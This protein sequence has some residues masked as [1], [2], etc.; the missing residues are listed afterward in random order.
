MSGNRRAPAREPRAHWILLLLS[1]LLLLAALAFNGYAHGIAGG[2][3]LPRPIDGAAAAPEQ[4][5]TGGPVIRANGGQV[6]SRRMPAK[7]IALT[8]DDGP[9]PEWTPK[10][11]D[12]LAKYQAH[13]TFF[14]I[15]S[16]V[17]EYPDLVRRM[18]AEGHEV[19]SHTFTHV[20]IARVA[21]WRRDL[22]LGMTRNAI[23]GAT[24]REVTLFR[25]PF[26]STADALHAYEV[27]A[28]PSDALTVL[29]D[30]D[31][32]DWQ[33]PGVDAIVRAAQPKGTAGA[34]VL[35]H[36]SGGDR[37]QTVQALAKLIPA[38][39]AKGYK[40][41]TVSEALGLPAAAPAPRAVQVRGDVLRTVQ[42]AA[43]FATDAM[44]VL[45]A[46]AL[47]LAVVRLLVQILA[48][49]RHVKVARR[50]WRE[51]PFEVLDPVSII[52]PAYNEA[53]NIA[54]TV[55][56]LVASDY[57]YLEVIVVDDGSTDHTADIVEGLRLRGVRVLRQA[58]AGKPAALTTG[59]RAAR[60]DLLI[61]VDGDTVFQRDTVYNLVQDFVDA[62]VGAIAGNTKVANRKGLLG[63]WQHLE[64]V[65]GFNLDRRLFDLAG[66]MPTI[67]GA[68]G[69]FRREVLQ[70]VAT[71]AGIVSPDTLA[72]DTDLTMAV[73]RAGWKV[74]YAE[75]A[76]AWTEAPSS[77]RQLWRQRYRWCYGT[78]QAMWKHRHAVVEGGGGGR[79]G[80][81]GLPYLLVFQVALPLA[82]P[83]V[84]VFAVYGFIFLPWV[85]ML[86]A[87]CGLLAIQIFTAWY[88]LRLDRERY[89]PL[90]SIAFQQIVYRQLMYLVVVQST[91]T[92]LLGNRLRWQRMQ[93]TG[94][95]AALLK[96]ASR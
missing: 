85:Q 72:E 87:W 56:S 73:L 54:A 77:L 3:E 10:V 32:E 31:T 50:R 5:L 49:R 88:A 43:G 94:E 83:A 68:I 23:A 1:L 95:A 96:S 86:A 92:A 71:S 13:G 22:E 93:R 25:P 59:I 91:V 79:L 21:G 62:Q 84:D 67:P 18:T 12:V 76:I 28:L 35:M 14:P 81:R 63:R 75:H 69:A 74:V 57:P 30:L 47:V 34:I 7:T 39:Q 53:A 55:R 64:Y 17:N 60:A 33:R 26:S 15:G 82:A 36:D 29:N 40:F 27:A 38:L 44:G 16:H 78:M 52:V 20:E 90:W 41:V 19:G 51:R 89:G 80:R 58:N 48:S 2:A 37:S 70:D 9:D 66:C 8:F 4:V 46:V 11:L 61:L 65:I 45:M 42:V 24:G 6:E